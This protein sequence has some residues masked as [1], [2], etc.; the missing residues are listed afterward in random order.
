MGRAAFS[1]LLTLSLPLDCL[2]L[3]ASF[4]LPLLLLVVPIQ[5][6]DHA[7]SLISLIS[8]S[9]SPPP[10]PPSHFTRTQALM[11]FH[12]FKRMLS[13]FDG[14]S[15]FSSD[16]QLASCFVLSKMVVIDEVE[17]QVQQ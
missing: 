6:Y 3:C 8:L 1:S 7:F 16:T 4:T 9:L 2:L 5:L 15:A 10:L 17:D 12:E 14:D 13:F 11:T